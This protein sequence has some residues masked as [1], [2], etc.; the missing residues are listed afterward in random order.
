[1]RP[2]DVR[3]L[4]GDVCDSREPISCRRFYSA[5]CA[6]FFHTLDKIIMAEINQQ[7]DNS[8]LVEVHEES[9]WKS[10]PVLYVR[11]V[12]VNLA[13]YAVVYFLAYLIKYDFDISNINHWFTKSIVWVLAIKMIVL[14]VSRAYRNIGYYATMRELLSIISDA[15]FSF[16]GIECHLTSSSGKSYPSSEYSSFRS[17]GF[18]INSAQDDIHIQNS[19]S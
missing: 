11:S 1:M 6:D 5:I 10:R 13:M 15:C 12:L 8:K 19:S 18:V 7:Y 14:Y 4:N 2:C 3:F 17:D 16:V 9:R